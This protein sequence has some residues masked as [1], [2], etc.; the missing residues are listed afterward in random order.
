M[1]CCQQVEPMWEHEHVWLSTGGTHVG[2]PHIV[3]HGLV[4]PA[5]PMEHLPQHSCMAMLLMWPNMPCAAGSVGTR[6]ATYGARPGLI[7][8]M[9]RMEHALA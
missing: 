4:I 8:I 9:P 6:H 3:Y 1:L 7:M 5:T 2:V